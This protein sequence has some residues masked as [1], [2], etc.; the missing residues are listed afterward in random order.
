ML[1]RGRAGGV[2]CGLSNGLG[3]D[4]IGDDGGIGHA[5]KADVGGGSLLGV[6]RLVL[7]ARRLGGRGHGGHT[8]L[9][10]AGPKGA[11]S[12]SGPTTGFK[13]REGIHQDAD[14]SRSTGSAGPWG[15]VAISAAAMPDTVPELLARYPIELPSELVAQQPLERRHDSRLLV[16]HGDRLEDR[17]VRDLPSLLDPGDLVVVNDSRV[18]PA[19]CLLRR[20]TGGRV[21]VFIL[22]TGPGPVEALVRPGRRLKPGEVLEGSEGTRVELLECRDDGSWLVQ[23][24]PEPLALMARIGHVPL[25][26]YIRREDGALDRD[27]YQT[28]YARPSGSAAAPTAGL[29]FSDELLG[30]LDERGVQ[31]ASVTLHVGPGT[32]RPL[33]QQDLDS[34]QLHPERWFVPDATVAAIQRARAAGK[35]VLA[36][37]TTTVRA[38]EA[39]TSAGETLPRAGSGITR[40]FL[41]E[42]DRLR[43]ATS[44]L[45]NFHLPGS[46]LILLVAAVLGRER[47]LEVYGQAIARRYRFYS[48]GD[49]MLVLHAA[50]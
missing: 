29:H 22:E 20:E 14:L 23:S 27:R 21:E 4:G 48:Y 24:D 15:W 31:L 3:D 7:A 38:L 26:P 49:A 39:A 34:G 6:G 5:G 10:G 16:D 25:P 12:I 47:L 43:V 9:G 19:R 41:G 40:L 42:G 2:G 8:W 50:R 32:F 35:R 11:G 33:R 1:R 13:P 45:T 17:R 36:V 28:V 46:S 44:L 37:G 18:M 30:A